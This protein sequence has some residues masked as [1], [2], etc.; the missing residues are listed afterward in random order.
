MHGKGG[1]CE[2]S[3]GDTIAPQISSIPEE[4]SLVIGSRK[5]PEEMKSKNF[6][7]TLKIQLE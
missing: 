7:K 5:I 2:K 6:F 1:R 4:S 3:A